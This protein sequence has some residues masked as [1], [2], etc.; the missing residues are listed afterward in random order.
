[1]TNRDLA[2]IAAGVVAIAALATVV[3]LLHER[4]PTTRPGP[5]D[6]GALATEPTPLPPL[7][8]EP[9]NDDTP[10]AADAQA[11]SPSAST[12][13]ARDAG[14]TRPSASA[15]KDSGATVVR[16]QNL[17]I[18]PV[19]HE[20]LCIDYSSHKDT[21]HLYSCH[22]HKNQRWTAT[23]DVGASIRLLN[24]EGGCVVVQGTTKEG[25][26]AMTLGACGT[27]AAR[28]RH[29]EEHKLQETASG[30]CVAARRIEKGITLS[31][32]ACDGSAGQAW[33]LAVE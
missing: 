8:P 4:R 32:Q 24:G 25:E 20:K 28:F 13:A 18:H 31:L 22:G 27:A 33:T 17:L 23:E 3:V 7:E 30:K 2:G 29:F 1:M 5:V 15:T 14:P 12:A 10:T 21:L 6:A 16:A 26:P 11:P 9:D 19:G